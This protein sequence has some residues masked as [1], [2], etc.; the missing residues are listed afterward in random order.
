MSLYYDELVAGNSF[1]QINITSTSKMDPPT[2]NNHH[3]TPS[4]APET[5]SLSSLAE[6]LGFPLDNLFQMA[7]QFLKGREREREKPSDTSSLLIGIS[8][9]FLPTLRETR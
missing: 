8:F 7:K 1:G 2:T 3:E 5:E 6:K 4:S 9:Y